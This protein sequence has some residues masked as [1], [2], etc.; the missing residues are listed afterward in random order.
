MTQWWEVI[1]PKVSG[2]KGIPYN[3]IDVWLR[4]RDVWPFALVMYPIVLTALCHLTLVKNNFKKDLIDLSNHFGAYLP[5]ILYGLMIVLVFTH[6]VV[7]LATYWSSSWCLLMGFTSKLENADRFTHIL[8]KPL[9]EYEKSVLCPVVME[10]K[11]D[12]TVI[13]KIEYFK[14]WY[15][16]DSNYNL[17]PLYFPCNKSFQFYNTLIKHPT[18][19]TKKNVVALHN[20]YGINNFDIELPSFMELFK[21]HL[22]APFFVFQIFCVVLWFLN[23]YWGHPLMTLALL[24]FLEVQLVFKRLLELKQLHD[25]RLNP[26]YVNVW[27]NGRWESLLSDA[28]VP[29]DLMALP[30]Q[31]FSSS[32]KSTEKKL[33]FICPCDALLVSGALMMNESTLTGESIPQC[34]IP[35]TI[36]EENQKDMLDMKSYHRQHILY[37]GTTVIVCKPNIASTLK[38]THCPVPVNTAA[39]CIVL[40]TGFNTTQGKIVRTVL[41]TSERVTG[42]NKEAML[43]LLILFFFSLLASGYVLWNWWDDVFILKNQSSR[44]FHKLLLNCIMIITS[45]VPP[46]FPITMSMAVTLSL[47]ELCKRK[48]FCTEPFRLPHAGHVTVCAFDKT[49]TLTSDNMK[50]CSVVL[51][52]A[53]DEAVDTIKEAIS[54]RDTVSLLAGQRKHDIPFSTCAILAACQSLVL[55]PDKQLA[56]DPVE[57]ASMTYTG[58]WRFKDHHSIHFSDAEFPNTLKI[59]RRFPFSSELRRMT[60]LVQHTGIP[61]KTQVC[62]TNDRIPLQSCT[63]FSFSPSCYVL[64]KGSPETIRNFLAIVPQYYDEVLQV[65]NRNGYRVIALGYKKLCDIKDSENFLQMSRA[66]LESSLTFGGF[67]VLLSS[68]KPDTAACLKKLIMSS[69]RLIM[70]TG[71]NILTACQISTDAGL[72]AANKCVG[73]TYRILQKVT[74]NSNDTLS[75]YW[76]CRDKINTFETHSNDQLVQA[77]NKY[78]LCL[79]GAGV[80]VLQNT[81]SLKN[82]GFTVKMITIFAQM[83]PRQKELIINTLKQEKFFVLMCGDGTNDVGALKAAHIGISLLSG[84]DVTKT[85]TSSTKASKATAPKA[86]AEVPSFIQRLQAYETENS[87]DFFLPTLG[88]ASY[89][90]AFTYKGSTIRCV[91]TILRYGRATLATVMMSYKTIAINALIT[92]FSLSVLTLDGVKLGDFQTTVENFFMSFLVFICSKAKPTKDLSTEKQQTRLFS[93]AVLISIFGQSFVHLLCLLIGWKMTTQL[94]PTD[95]QRNLDG[96]FSPNLTNTVIFY[97]LAASHGS[98]FLANYTGPPH[99]IPLTKNR[100]FFR[101]LVF[102]FAMIAITTLEIFPPLNHMFSLVLLPSHK[103][104][105]YVFSLLTF[106]VTCSFL[107]GQIFS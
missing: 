42:E 72:V 100:L 68:I 44:S 15:T 16:V 40:R 57:I 79:D 81:L 67:L 14:K 85:I 2:K 17:H 61:F 97:I 82:F 48:I 33:E 76:S 36:T 10:T 11:E 52:P 5:F 21:Q 102:F 93:S 90:S 69:Y 6:I 54:N 84:E 24:V 35:L 94:R 89:A 32:G 107:I 99:M 65:L 30:R 22:V 73:D 77:F 104:K 63:S 8:V 31:E 53:K 38:S 87:P 4:R 103:F 26:H 29:G 96:E 41:F 55:L 83:A 49:G 27:R 28:L 92:A 51:L 43:F 25:M 98:T 23:E 74:K 62:T 101:G 46:E 37:A 105:I 12:G 45:V 3:R 70:I 39:C 91:P 59:L 7:H 64:S 18:G 66:T 1:N 9:Q 20:R 78:I 13:K 71:D 75:M 50:I 60:V 95:Y 58:P 86:L 80:T 88:I 106:D 34:K 56:G 47:A 19:L